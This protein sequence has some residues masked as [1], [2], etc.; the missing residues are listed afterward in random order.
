MIKPTA[1]I[2]R[3]LHSNPFHS[4]SSK[5]RV[6]MAMSS[7]TNGHLKGD[8]FPSSKSPSIVL[9]HPTPEEHLNQLSQNGV[10]W[11]GALSLSAYLRREAHLAEQDATR[12]GGL[13][14]WVLVDQADPT[15]RRVLAGCDT[16]RKKALVAVKGAIRET[17]AHGI[18]S[19]FCPEELRGKGYA[20]VLMQK[21]G[22]VLKTWQTDESLF[23]VLFSDIGKSY[24]A[25]Y[26]WEPFPSS[27]ISLPPE[28]GN[29]I[30]ILPKANPLRAS[31]LADLCA[32]DEALIRKSLD[33]AAASSLKTMVAILPD[34]QTI[35]WHHAREEFVGFELHSEAP[36][37]KGAIVGEKVGERVWCY[38]ARMFYNEDI[39]KR[40]ENTLHILRL[41]IEAEGLVDWE[42]SIFE[43]DRIKQYIPSIA[44]LLVMAQEEA[45]KW[46]M[47]DV[48][49]WNP[50]HVTVEAAKSLYPAMEV[51][52]RDYESVCCLRWY[53]DAKSLNSIQWL[54]NEKYGWC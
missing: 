21:I 42:T 41:V 29:N 52:H 53:G 18:G 11:R 9:A 1:V 15:K 6:K 7:K 51:V 31:D 49:V 39:E 26:G 46:N 38:W 35:R 28:V 2:F 45:G 16:Y 19:V 8:D 50:N 27:H 30:S 48:Q 47:E 43:E 37:I 3:P 14:T 22:E 32:I 33:Q 34:I 40:E 20:G 13:T 23:S 10:A 25:R 54:G 12:D 4:Y 17:V 24:Y 5:T 36:E 44:A